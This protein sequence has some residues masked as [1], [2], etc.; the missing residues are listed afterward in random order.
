MGERDWTMMNRF[1]FLVEC[2]KLHAWTKKFLV[3]ATDKESAEHKT[4]EFI[5]RNITGSHETV[6]AQYL[7]NKEYVDD[8][9]G[10]W[11]IH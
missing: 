11:V 3:M 8:V 1:P 5:Y 9:G 6:K 7:G 2:D 4:Q 10:F